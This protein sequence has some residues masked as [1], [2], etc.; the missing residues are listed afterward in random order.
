MR[1]PRERS[2]PLKGILPDTNTTAGSGK[3]TEDQF[4]AAMADA[5]VAGTVVSPGIVEWGRARARLLRMRAQS[6]LMRYRGLPRWRVV[7][8]WR[9]LREFM[10]DT[11]LADALEATFGK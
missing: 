8:R 2:G 11:T 6:A 3:V 5:A 7:R 1:P 10:D 9:A 4:F